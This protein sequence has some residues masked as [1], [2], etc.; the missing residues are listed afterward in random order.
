MNNTVANNTYNHYDETMDYAIGADDSVYR[1]DVN[2]GGY[3]PL[4]N[5]TQGLPFGLDINV[6]QDRLVL[7]GTSSTSAW[8]Q[9]YAID[10]S[11][12]LT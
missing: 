7:N 9:A 12:T 3:D 10:P 2:T 1:Y 4:F 11:G 8:V 6:H 5:F